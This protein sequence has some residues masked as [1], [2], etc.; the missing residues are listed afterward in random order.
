MQDD[1][2]EPGPG[3][4]PASG[5]ERTEREAGPETEPETAVDRVLGSGLFDV[6]WYEAQADTTFPDPA[7]AVEH[8]LARGRRS[9][10]SPHPLFV[11]ARFRPQ[12]WQRDET[13]PLLTYLDGAGDAW[14]SVTSPLFDPRLLD[15]TFLDARPR[16]D[17]PSGGAPA[18]PRSPLVAFLQEAG[19]TAALPVAPEAAWLREG[20]TL[21]DVRTALHAELGEAAGHTQGPGPETPG[22]TVAGAVSVVVVDCGSTD[23]VTGALRSVD[24][25]VRGAGGHEPRVDV[26][27]TLVV[28]GPPRHVVVGLTLARL[29]RYDVRALPVPA[30][31]AVADAV[32]AAARCARG[33]HLLLTSS[34]HRFKEGTLDDWRTALAASGAAAVHPLVLGSTLLVRDVGVVYPPR[35]T[36]PVPFLRG[37]HPDG[38]VWPR[39]WFTVPGAP[40]P[41]LARTDT[42]RTAGQDARQ[43]EAPRRLWSDIDLSQRL[44]AH[45]GRP[46][47]VVRDLVTV[48]SGGGVLDDVSEAE[49]DLA[50]FRAAWRDVPAGSAELFE[51][52]RLAPVF[53]G[54]AA[55]S[56]PDR[57]KSWTRA[58][59]LP[60]PD[61]S[62]VREAPPAL[63]WAVKTATPAA[64]RARQWGDFHFAHS[65]A[66]ALRG[67]GQE[68]VVDHAPNDARETSYRDDVVLVLRGLRAVRLPADVTSVVWVISHPEDVT[69][70]ELAAYD[71]RYA[72]S[73]TWPSDVSE[74]W[75]LPVRPLLQCTDPSRF[76]V[77]DEPVEEVL[78]KAVLVGNSRNQARPV[79]VESARSGAAL[80]VYGAHWEKFLPPGV[81][82]GTYV[83]NEIL[84]R[85]YRSAAWALNDHWPDMRELGFVANRVFDVLASGGRLLTDH[86]DGLDELVGPVAPP[87]GLATFRTTEELHALLAQDGRDWYDDATLRA[88][89][90]HVRTEH[91]FA[92]RAARLVEDVAAHRARVG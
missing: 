24:G 3:R 11:P 77:D 87:R 84:R 52:F 14:T 34:R 62:E 63:R 88:L 15:P 9:G 36:D 29:A 83:P 17:A 1:D 22:D 51:T 56:A 30:G 27:V 55:L 35:G 59:W 21:Q 12:R 38:V 79:A 10:W 65:L 49:E 32:D 74:R 23:D 26:G 89:S 81:V 48:R 67:L 37:V 41:L 6:E 78:D 71:L 7:A 13:D 19:P 42:V 53:H 64:D 85:Y 75:G 28:P 2:P 92:A 18:A 60:A 72:A 57:P 66:A 70:R 40:V 90:E 25:L 69:A 45:E 20:V 68:A 31:R 5:T 76:Y 86:V 4:E 8:Y 16:D 44:A 80:A 54:V 46:V 58:M 33:E 43:A 50:A 61:R 73:L 82:A 39:P 91:S 47:V